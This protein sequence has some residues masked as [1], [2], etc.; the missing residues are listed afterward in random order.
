M[1]IKLTESKLRQII[2]EEV[3]KMVEMYD[4]N[5]LEGMEGGDAE[6]HRAM[7]AL[8][9][10]L[11]GG[12]FDPQG[13]AMAIREF[14]DN[15]RNFGS[16]LPVEKDPVVFL[17]LLSEAW[18]SEAGEYF[19]G[20]FMPETMRRAMM[21]HKLYLGWEAKHAAAIEAAMETYAM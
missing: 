20:P 15:N 9:R 12:M 16:G 2:R 21:C 19:E 13:L 7:N 14:D 5:S 11:K 6:A 10:E 3:K 18:G 17:D 8:E 1:A 4:D